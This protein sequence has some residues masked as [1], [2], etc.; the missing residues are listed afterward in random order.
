MGIP[1]GI[2][3]GIGAGTPAIAACCCGIA[4]HLVVTLQQFLA[5]RSDPSPC[6]G[7]VFPE[8]VYACQID[9]VSQI[10]QGTEATDLM[11]FV[12]LAVGLDQASL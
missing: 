3:C 12:L 1:G 9:A 10:Q 6:P 2:G 11:A 8:T 7:A 4:L 5:E